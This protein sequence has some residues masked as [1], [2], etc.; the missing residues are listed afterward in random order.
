MNKSRI[1]SE[2]KELKEGKEQI[3]IHLLWQLEQGFLLKKAFKKPQTNLS[4]AK[5]NSGEIKILKPR[6]HWWE[7]LLVSDSFHKTIGPSNDGIPLLS[8][9]DSRNSVRGIHDEEKQVKIHQPVRL[10]TGGMLSPATKN[11]NMFQADNL[12]RVCGT[13]FGEMRYMGDSFVQP[14]LAGV[15][16]QFA[17]RDS[18]L[19]THALLSLPTTHTLQLPGQTRIS[20]F[21]ADG[22]PCKRRDIS[23]RWAAKRSL[24]AET[25]N[26]LRTHTS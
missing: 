23:R 17:P 22:T 19:L 2:T 8:R 13:C 7:C 24:E 18:N 1:A 3:S 11:S 6:Y 10:L 20:R 14:S 4:F 26:S 16:Y 9:R 12:F 5:A 21:Y 15:C 25:V